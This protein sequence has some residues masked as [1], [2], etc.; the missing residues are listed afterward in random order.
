MTWL[1]MAWLVAEVQLLQ[2]PA[3]AEWARRQVTERQEP[4]VGLQ[5]WG[6]ASPQAAQVQLLHR[7]L[8]AGPPAQAQLR[9]ELQIARLQV[10]GPVQ[11]DLHLE[12]A[13]V[14]QE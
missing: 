14:H 3:A 7:Q 9:A 13:A 12:Y 2:G 5:E 8:K 11:P 1:V 6:T 10:D 4:F